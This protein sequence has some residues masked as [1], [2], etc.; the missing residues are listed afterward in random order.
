M[1]IFHSK[2]STKELIKPIHLIMKN[3]LLFLL[4]F[5]PFYCSSQSSTS[6]PA[7]VSFVIYGGIEK[8]SLKETIE[9]NTIKLIN[10]LNSAYTKKEVLPKFDT[11]CISQNG[12]EAVTDLWKVGHFYFTENAISEILLRKGKSF[13]IRNIPVSFG[14]ENGTEIVIGYLTNGT[15]DTLYMALDVYITKDVLGGKIVEDQ[16]RRQIILNFIENLRTYYFKKDIDNIEKLYSDKALIIVGKVLET[17]NNPLDQ[18][19]T[20]FTSG[21]AIYLVRTKKE[22]ID[23][24]REVFNNT[25]GLLVNFKNIEVKIHPKNKN[26][27]GVLLRQTWQSSTYSDDGW[28]F[29]LFQFKES[30]QHL[31]WVRTWQDLR[32]TKSGDVFGLHNFKIPE[33]VITN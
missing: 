27:Y 3:I 29:L 9:S 10:C 13:Q 4:A 2:A 15:I 24:L 5:Y 28:L 18:I 32:D 22:Y 30:G 11:K 16:T 25:S 26:F 12:I 31:I 14:N 21:Q 7:N 6:V 1:R 17:V 20:T 23:T 19:P 8:G 33:G